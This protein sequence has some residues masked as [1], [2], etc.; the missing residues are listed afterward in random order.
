MQVMVEIPDDLAPLLIPAG[1]DPARAIL[2]DALVQAYRE[3]KI[4]GPQLMAT[5]G[6]E[7]RYELDGFLKARQVW[8]EYSLEQMEADRKFQDAFLAQHLQKSA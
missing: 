3:D 8:I 4:S 5:L 6:I 7:T 1:Q 2:E